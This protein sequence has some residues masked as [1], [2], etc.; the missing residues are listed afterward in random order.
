M[1]KKKLFMEDLDKDRL[2]EAM[3]AKH[4]KYIDVAGKDD[5]YICDV[6]TLRRARNNGRISRTLLDAIGKKLDVSP[7][8]LSGK[9]DWF[10]KEEKDPEICQ[11]YKDEFLKPERHSYS[12]HLLEHTDYDKTFELIL[13]S[14]G[15]S[16]QEYRQQ[17]QDVQYKIESTIDELIVRI[18]RPYF[19]SAMWAR[20]IQAGFG[21]KDMTVEDV[22]EML[23]PVLIEKGLMP[24]PFEDGEFL[25]SWNGAEDPFSEKYVRPSKTSD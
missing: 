2:K 25:R 14:H 5:D 12:H 10:L 16:K 21:Y 17:P 1:T 9:Y 22:Y 4:M 23:M 20:Y 8:Y 18:L 13:S 15:V 11:V 7:D 19:P 3:A 6:V 24:D